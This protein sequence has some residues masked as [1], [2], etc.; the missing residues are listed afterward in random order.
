[1]QSGQSRTQTTGRMQGG[2][3]QGGQMQGSQMQGGQMQSGM[4]G[5]ATGT[6]LPQQ[7]RMILDYVAQAVQVCGFC[8]DQCIQEASPQMI[9]CIR[10]CEEVVELGETV[11]A[12][13]PRNSRYATT[14][15]Q[16]FQQAAQDC[17]QE[18]GQ[19]QHDHCQECATVLNQTIQTIQQYGMTGQQSTSGGQQGM[20]TQM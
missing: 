8:A 1:M 4:T 6:T 16:A 18:C 20:T 5:Q 3:M 15:L 14:L 17:A 19:H 13:L 9:G 10:S 2:Q 7:H 11:M 12:L